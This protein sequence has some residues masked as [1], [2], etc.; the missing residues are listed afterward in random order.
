[1][2]P[3]SCVGSGRYRATYFFA[4]IVQRRHFKAIAMYARSHGPSPG[5]GK[6]TSDAIP[7]EANGWVGDNYPGYRNVEMDQVCR[8]IPSE[9]DEEKRTRLLRMS[10]SILA[11]D[12]P[13][14]PLYYRSEFVAVKEGLQNIAQTGTP[15]P[16]P[17]TR[18]RGTGNRTNARYMGVMP[19]W[20][21]HTPPGRRT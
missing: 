17:G 19:P 16:S 20:P 3:P 18:T 4:D 12:L 5:C 2:L 10:A 21:N 6:Y 15:R 9:L 8:A 11:R 14:L 1:M 7:S 13:V